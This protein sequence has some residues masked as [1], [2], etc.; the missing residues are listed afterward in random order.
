MIIGIVV[1]IVTFVVVATMLSRQTKS[2]K[3]QAIEDLKAEKES[4]GTFDI[5]ELVESEINA[6]GL[7]EIEGAQDLEHA[8]LLKVWSGSDE[9]VSSCEG[10]EHLR[11]VVAG[12]VNPADATENDVTLECTQTRNG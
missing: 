1:F 3:K 8:V 9:I 7:L 6:L 11:Y 5:F 12:G 2:A 10:R 4:V